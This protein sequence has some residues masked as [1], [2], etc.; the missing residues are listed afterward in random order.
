MTTILLAL[1]ALSAVLVDLAFAPG[2]ALFGVRPQFTLVV[3]ALW[4]ALRPDLEVMLLAPVAGLLLGLLGNETLGASVLA[5]APAVVLGLAIRGRSTH[6]R[7]ILTMGLVVVSTLA[8]AVVFLLVQMLAGARP[9]LG[10][11]WFGVLSRLS[12]V[13]AL[14]AA[15]LYWP[16]A[17]L[18]SDAEARDHFPRF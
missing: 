14:L 5:L 2:A 13:N 11:E 17:H 18:P 4:A 9:A 15:A 10:L 8:F 6:R 1:L 16:I 7:L 3:I 12:L